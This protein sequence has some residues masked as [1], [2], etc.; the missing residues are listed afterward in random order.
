MAAGPCAA[1]LV[2]VHLCP[3]MLTWIGEDTSQSY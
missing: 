1:W 3:G 2:L